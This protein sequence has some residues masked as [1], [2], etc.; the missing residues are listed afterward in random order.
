MLQK[1]SNTL[2][3]WMVLWYAP[4]V[5]LAAQMFPCM[6]VI[7]TDDVGNTNTTRGDTFWVL[8]ADPNVDCEGNKELDI[9]RG[10]ACM[11][12]LTVGIGF[13]Y[14]VR[15][16]L[17]K[18]RSRGRLL[19][20]STFVSVFHFYKDE[21][22]AFEAAQFV[23]KALLIGAT[24]QYLP[25]PHLPNLGFDFFSLARVEALA[26]LIINVGFLT[27]L[28]YYKVKRIFI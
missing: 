2:F 24:V 14:F 1:L 13:P 4:V 3:F 11:I 8:V 28:L 19:V 23:R 9:A 26:V 10:H 20:N 6:D 12:L 27:A 15:W 18:L 17:N 5:R 21:S 25:N 16:K 7:N 22:A